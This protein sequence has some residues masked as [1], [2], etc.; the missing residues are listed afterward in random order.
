MPI[1]QTSGRSSTVPAARDGA[2]ELQDELAAVA[3]DIQHAAMRAEVVQAHAG[4]RLVAR[5][6]RGDAHPGRVCA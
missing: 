5:Q 4:S 1:S 6:G 3:A 2:A